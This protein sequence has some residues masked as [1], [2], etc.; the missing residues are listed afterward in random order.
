[1]LVLVVGVSVSAMRSCEDEVCRWWWKEPGFENPLTTTTDD[2]KNV[3]ADT[4][5]T[6][7]HANDLLH[8]A[9]MMNC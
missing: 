2:D 1:V 4:T 5:A 6:T 7:T 8:G 3:I 9:T